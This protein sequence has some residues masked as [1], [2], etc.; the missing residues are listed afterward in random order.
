MVIAQENGIDLSEFATAYRGAHRL[1]GKQDTPHAN[2]PEIPP[3]PRPH[4]PHGRRALS[5]ALT[6]AI[7][8]TAVTGAIQKKSTEDT[9]TAIEN[10]GPGGMIM[11]ADT[12]P[13]G[14]PLTI[15]LDSAGKPVVKLDTDEPDV[16]TW[17]SD[18]TGEQDNHW[19]Y[20]LVLGPKYDSKDPYG[21]GNVKIVMG[22]PENDPDIVF[23]GVWFVRVTVV[24]G[25]V[26]PAGNDGQ[27]LA[28]GEAPIYSQADSIVYVI[29]PA[30]Q[31]PVLV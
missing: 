28:P 25:E 26:L 21:L 8:A 27:V 5:V 6:V 2:V 29:S 9:S 10:I 14:K 13:I 3:L 17:R 15:N 1:R 24:N 22:E 16:W 7:V 12:F 23:G 4:V 30:P 18:S 11:D 31:E 19:Q 20:L